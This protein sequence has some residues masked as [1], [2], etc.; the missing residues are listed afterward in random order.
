[1]KPGL[2]ACLYC[3]LS[4]RWCIPGGWPKRHPA[5]RIAPAEP[6]H[7]R[8]LLLVLLEFRLPEHGKRG[9][10]T[11]TVTS[12]YGP[13]K[14]RRM[15][16]CRTCKAR[17]SEREGAPLFDSRPPAEKVESVPEHIAEGCGVRRTG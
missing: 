13:E 10:G 6:L 5:L 14:A 11:L 1:M 8:P 16:R 2:V 7:G 17:S 3:T 15:L 9:G 12:R 4:L